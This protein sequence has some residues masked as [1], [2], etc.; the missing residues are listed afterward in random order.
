MLKGQLPISDVIDSNTPSFDNLFINRGRRP[1]SHPIKLIMG[2][3]VTD[4][5]EGWCVGMRVEVGECD[6]GGAVGVGAVL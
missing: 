3:S 1:E 5:G 4:V 2:P 6:G